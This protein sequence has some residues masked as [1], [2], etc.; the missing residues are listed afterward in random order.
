MKCKIL[1]L[2]LSI[3]LFTS[4]QESI[5]E[6]QAISEASE[7]KKPKPVTDGTLT[8]T[9]DAS[10]T[11]SEIVMKD[12]KKN[13]IA[14]QFYSNGKIWK[15]VSYKDGKLDGEAKIYDEEGRLQ[16]VV[17]YKEGRN[18][19]KLVKYFKSGNAKVEAEYN[20]G[21][22]MLGIVER[23]YRG[24]DVKQP[25]ITF[26]KVDNMFKDNT[27]SVI[28]KLN[29]KAKDVK[30]YAG[31]SADFWKPETALGVHMIPRDPSNKDQYLINFNVPKGFYLAQQLHVYATYTSSTGEEAVTYKAVN[32]AAENPAY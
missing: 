14:K 24:K 16:R 3:C 1:I 8:V 27:Y 5:V 30:F 9:N 21:M 25:E 26:E 20:D 10:N 15:E 13:G 23:D 22:P 12:G 31:E 7:K 4:C 17:N 11:T 32:I 2:C 6:E 29:K 19:G 28:F 18:H